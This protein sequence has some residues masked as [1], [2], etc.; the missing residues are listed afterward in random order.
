[1]GN[2]LLWYLYMCNVTLDVVGKIGPNLCLFKGVAGF[3]TF[4][5]ISLIK[6]SG[7]FISAGSQ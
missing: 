5:K 3:S 2:P 1:M 6:L 4:W 7:H